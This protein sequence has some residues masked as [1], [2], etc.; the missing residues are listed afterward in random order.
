M[1][2]INFSCVGDDL[3]MTEENLSLNSVNGK[4]GTL[5]V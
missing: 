1:D 2:G 5:A 3:K 4:I